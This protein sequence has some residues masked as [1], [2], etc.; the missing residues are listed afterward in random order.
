MRISQPSFF[1]C[2]TSHLLSRPSE[3]AAVHNKYVS[4]WP[5]FRGPGSKDSELTD[6][7]HVNETGDTQRG[8]LF[9]RDLQRHY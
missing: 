7:I 8:S 4:R 1:A 9:V 5:T 6:R 3:V 2:D